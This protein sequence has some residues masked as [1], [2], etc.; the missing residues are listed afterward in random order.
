MERKMLKIR[1]EIA[2]RPYQLTISADE[3]ERVR[4]AARQ[5]RDQI[6]SL[7]RKYEASL[8]E[9]LAMAAMRISIENEENKERLRMSPEALRLRDLASELDRWAGEESDS[10]EPG[11]RIVHTPAPIVKP[12]GRRGRPRKNRTDSDS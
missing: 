6:E 3:E 9:Y 7:K 4:R 1:V 10:D 2:E 8:T 5:I 11:D 12:K